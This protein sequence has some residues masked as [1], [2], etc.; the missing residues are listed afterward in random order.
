MI[1]NC[2]C[3]SSAPSFISTIISRRYF[4]ISSIFLPC[5]LESSASLRISSATTANPAPAVPAWAASIAAFIASM[6]V[7]FAMLRMIAE[8][9]IRAADSSAN[10]FV[11]STDLTTTAR[12]FSADSESLRTL[13]E[14]LSRISVTELM[15][16]TICSIEEED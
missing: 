8:V 11:I 4:M 10:L 9:S 3:V 2:F 12:P 13:S 7:W 5:L 14:F 6:F 16:A 1:S 15:F